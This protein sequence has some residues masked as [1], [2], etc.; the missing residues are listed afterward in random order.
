[1]IPNHPEFIEAINEKKKV[2][3]RYYSIPDSGVVD[4]VC[5][6]M[7]YGPG[8]VYHDGL[9]RYW[10]WVDA[11]N[12]GSRILGLLPGEVVNLQVLGEVFDPAE[13]KDRPAQWFTPRDWG[14]ES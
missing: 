14:S 8:T 10:L 9:N 2:R 12:A 5:A 1:M 4:R 6:P 13:F 3:V 7:D 11:V